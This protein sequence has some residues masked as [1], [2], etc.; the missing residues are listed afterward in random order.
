MGTGSGTGAG[1]GSGS[2]SGS[3][4]VNTQAVGT[5]R[6][7]TDKHRCR[8]RGGRLAK[9]LSAVRSRGGTATWLRGHPAVRSAESAVTWPHRR[10]AATSLGRTVARQRGHLAARLWPRRRLAMRSPGNAV[11]RQRCHSAAP[12][13]GNAVT[14]QR[15]HSAARSTRVIW[16]RGHPAAR[17]RGCGSTVVA[18]RSPGKAVTWQ[19]RHPEAPSPEAPSPGGAVVLA[20][21]ASWRRGCGHDA[22]IRS[23]SAG[24]Y[25][26]RA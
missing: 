8:R 16:Q 3:G 26:P 20:A 21:R 12:S 6:A 5:T 18:A 22:G 19:R 7:T 11:T 9:R 4:V 13:P 2:G 10:L 17:P 14:R 23:R 25:R 15:C 1:T 24:R